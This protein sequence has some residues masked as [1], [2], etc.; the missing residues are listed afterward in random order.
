MG[1]RRANREPEDGARL[2]PSNPKGGTYKRSKILDGINAAAE[3][4]SAVTLRQVATMPRAA[5]VVDYVARAGA[6]Q[7]PMNRFNEGS[8]KSEHL[9]PQINNFLGQKSRF[10]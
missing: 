4:K 2:T 8:V 7:A 10:Y 3:P 9:V 1:Y 5:T 6:P